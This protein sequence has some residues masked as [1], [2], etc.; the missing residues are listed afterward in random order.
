[1]TLNGAR[2]SNLQS[3]GSDG[4][5]QIYFSPALVVKANN[6]LN[7]DL[8]VY[9]SGANS[10]GQHY[11]SILNSNAVD[12]SAETVGGSFPASTD[13]MTTTNY[14]VAPVTFD[15][16]G[17]SNTVKVGDHSAELGQFKLNNG[18]ANKTLNFKAITLRNDGT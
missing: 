6:S 11:F 7:L 1:M 16:G 15:V 14:T 9:F 13:T 2:V 10:N 12:T 5:T 17:T 18:D 3:L 4:T 8:Q